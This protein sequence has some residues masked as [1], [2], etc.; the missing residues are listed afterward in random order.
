MRSSTVICLSALALAGCSKGREAK[1]Y[2]DA[3]PAAMAAPAERPPPP[4]VVLP[5]IVQPASEPA[6][7]ALNVQVYR[8]PAQITPPPSDTL[9][10]YA[11]TYAIEAPSTKIEALQQANELAC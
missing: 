3:A 7:E 4:Q 6:A 2:A 5:D 8:P 11:Y 10:A 9:L 1:A